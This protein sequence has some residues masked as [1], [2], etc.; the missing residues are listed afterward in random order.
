M[1][2]IAIGG[3]LEPADLA[4]LLRETGDLAAGYERVLVDVRGLTHNLSSI[5]TLRLVERYS[6]EG[7]SRR[8][9][10]VLE[11]REQAA[12]H[13]FHETVAVNRGFQILHF[14]D[15]AKAEA[16]LKTGRQG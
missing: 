1:L 10:A 7:R 15:E 3:T 12:S 16:W 4:G 5:E 2:R 14:T 13:H 8:R 11:T 6:P 9:T